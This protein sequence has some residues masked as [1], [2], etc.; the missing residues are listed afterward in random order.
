VFSD[1]QRHSASISAATRR[2]IRAHAAAIDNDE[3]RQSPKLSAAFFDILRWKHGVY[4]ALH[5]MHKLGV[6]GAYL[7]E[8]GN[9]LCMAQYD[10]VHL[11]TVDEHSLRGVLFLERLR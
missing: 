3:A 5:E 1:A 6:L 10:R 11:Y 2:S 8:F 4:D 7:P 9:L